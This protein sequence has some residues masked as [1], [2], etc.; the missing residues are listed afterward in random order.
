MF[1]R[2]QRSLSGPLSTAYSPE[3]QLKDAHFSMTATLA[4]SSAAARAAHTPDRPA[5]TT[6]TS[7]SIT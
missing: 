2:P 6:T 1:V 4:P 5:P 7:T 3:R